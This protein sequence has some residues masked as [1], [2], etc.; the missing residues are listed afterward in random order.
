VS[1]TDL[2]MRAT[3]DTSQF[4]SGMQNINSQIQHLGFQTGTASTSLGGLGN[5]IGTLANPMTLAAAGAVALGGALVGSVQA[6]AAFETAMSGAAKTIGLAGPELEALGSQLL[7]MSTNM[8]VAAESLAGIAAVAGSLGIAQGDIAGF[9][10]TAAMMSVAFEMPAEQAATMGAKILNAFQQP[11]SSMSNLGNT[12]NAMGDSFAATEGQVLDFLNRASFLNTTFG[13][14]IPQV[15]ALGTTLISAGMDADTAATGIKSL[16]NM[17]LN[18]KNIGAFAETLGVAVEDVGATL[19]NDLGG[20]LVKVADQL[21][22]IEDPAERFNAAVKL[23]GTEGAPALLKLAGQADNLKSAMEKAN[24][25][26]ENG[27]SMMATFEANSATLNS[28]LQIFKNV[29][30]QAA[31]E[32]GNVLLP[33]VTQGIKLLTDFAKAAIDAG[34]AVYGWATGAA[35]TVGGWMEGADQWIDDSY[36]ALTGKHATEGIA[37]GIEE[38]ADVIAD[39]VEDA[40]GGTEAQ[41]AAEQAGQDIAGAWRKGWEE[42]IGW[43]GSSWTNEMWGWASDSDEGS[44]WITR[45]AEYLGQQLTYAYD[46]A[47]TQMKSKLM[48][49]GVDLIS[50]NSSKIYSEDQLLAML[51]LP[52]RAEM[53]AMGLAVGTDAAQNIIQGMKDQIPREDIITDIEIYF[54]DEFNKLGE[55]SGEA[56]KDGILTVTEQDDLLGTAQKLQELREEYPSIFEAI[57]GESSAALIDAILAGDWDKVAELGFQVGQDFKRNLVGGAALE[58]QSLADLIANPEEMEKAIANLDRWQQG[59]LI[60]TLNQNMA[61]VKRAYESGFFTE[62]QIFEAYIK[63]LETVADYMPGWLNDLM[64]MYEQGRIDLE[65][66]LYVYEGMTDQLK[67]TSEVLKEQS[68]GYDQLKEAIGDCSEC[69]MSD[70]GTWQEAQNDLFQDSYIG[71]GGQDYLTW[72]MQQLQE[73]A[74]TADAMRAVGG[75]PLGMSAE[76]TLEPKLDQGAVEAEGQTAAEQMESQINSTTAIM[77]VDVDLRE[78]YTN[79]GHLVQ[80]IENLTVYIP[81][82]ISVLVSVDDIR[83]IV[84]SV[85]RSA[86]A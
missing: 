37:E 55:S 23:A 49:G 40:T 21:M 42:K 78:A 75:Q 6:A 27:S 77:P 22:S 2:A 82:D 12:V 3:L 68:K 60:P 69:V 86:L 67:E 10:E 61:D 44:D 17:S 26:W 13:Q 24:S 59:T 14:T 85:V 65:G 63:P 73:M 46:S 81:V 58:G 5:V 54:R 25:E 30:N 56:L 20:S 79:W 7:E 66:F 15:A 36:F 43:S 51:G 39:A 45:T 19:E 50:Q 8:P 4:A 70:F 52:P 64:A 34:E 72:K 80:D 35:D 76:L 57:G 16:L 38:N 41:A 1:D 9:V 32:L 28:Q 31:V 83:G 29:I 84:E 53:E 74:A 47:G 33:Y 71:P 11:T 18:E 48:V 62:D